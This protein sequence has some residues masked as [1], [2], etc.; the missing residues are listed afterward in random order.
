L[1]EAGQEIHHKAGSQVVLDA[2]AEITLKAGGSFVKLDPSGVTIVG[3][4]V[5]INSGGSP[6]RG[7]GQAAQEPLLPKQA[8]AEAHEKVLAPK[9]TAS[10]K[11][12]LSNV[13]GSG[14]RVFLVD[15]TSGRQNGQQVRLRKGRGQKNGGQQG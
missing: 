1:T 3:A 7:T 8:M 4:Q 11:M 5:R 6:G 13:E 10:K 2:G 15:V 9:H 14:Q 12:S